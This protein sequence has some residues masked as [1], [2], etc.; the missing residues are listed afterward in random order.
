[1]SQLPEDPAHRQMRHLLYMVIA[2]LAIV[3]L[4]LYSA[5]V[6]I[7][8]GSLWKTALAVTALWVGAMALQDNF[9][10]WRQARRAAARQQTWRR[11]D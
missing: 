9:K 10:Q 4:G 2:G 3:G 11:N 6:S 5:V 8:S 1:M 7:I